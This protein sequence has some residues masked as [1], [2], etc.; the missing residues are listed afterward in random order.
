MSEEGNTINPAAD[1]NTANSAGTAA[2]IADSAADA[3]LDVPNLLS[4]INT[5]PTALRQYYNSDDMT[6]ARA[7]AFDKHNLSDEDEAVCFVTE[8]QVAAQEIP[9][10]EFPDELWNRLD[11]DESKE[12]EA[13]QLVADMMGYILLPMSAFVGDVIGVMHEY[14][15]R[16][17]SYPNK[18][19]EARVIT[20]DKATEEILEAI[21]IRGLNKPDEKRLKH[22]IESRLRD[23][24][25][26]M[27]TRRMLTKPHKTG[28]LE[29]TDAEA[30]RILDHVEQEMRMT[31]YVEEMPEE[32]ETSVTVGS[33]EREVLYEQQ[34]IKA[35]LVGPADEQKEIAKQMQALIEKTEG[36][37]E[38]MREVL[39]G[40]LYPETLEMPE[41]SEVVAALMLFA[42][43]GDIVSSL[44]DDKRFQGVIKAY[45]QQAGKSID[46][47]I[48]NE[49]GGPKAM[50]HFL[51]I[52]LRGFAQLSKKDSARYGLRIIN[53][54]NKKGETQYAELVAFD[55]DQGK[56]VW[57]EPIDL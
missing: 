1:M 25:D 41:S 44:L 47:E 51:Q 12:K 4:K 11:W 6:A 13:G 36:N 35:I 57:N 55:M 15:M 10:E 31:K 54:L 52:V 22:I 23:V 49:P 30:V 26:E 42:R 28:G 8:L 17:E 24:R 21:D 33:K 53:A 38:M 2:N 27:E 48:L 14:G 20:Y 40:Y 19:I 29:L 18:S 46:K 5:L 3:R 32:S 34:D 7:K 37:P 50:N 39:N 43:Q 9:I 56:F 16:P 45:F